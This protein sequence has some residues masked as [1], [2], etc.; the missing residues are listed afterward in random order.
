M[1]RIFMLKGAFFYIFSCDLYDYL[2]NREFEPPQ[3]HHSFNN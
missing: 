1:F 3:P 2:K